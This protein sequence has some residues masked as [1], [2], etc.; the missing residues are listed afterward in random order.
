MHV[1]PV[2]GLHGDVSEQAVRPGGD[3]SQ[4]GVAA[5][6]QPV[7]VRPV[8]DEQVGQVVG[9]GH[10]GPQGPVQGLLGLGRGYGDCRLPP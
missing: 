7:P 4:H 10:Q 9:E 5:V 3:R 2:L 6:D 1:A 8:Q